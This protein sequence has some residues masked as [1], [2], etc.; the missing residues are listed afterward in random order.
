MDEILKPTPDALVA[1]EYY[2]MTIDLDGDTI[3][4]MIKDEYYDYKKKYYEFPKHL[5]LSKNY[6]REIYD[7][8]K[9]RYKKCLEPEIDYLFGMKVI[10]TDKQSVLKVY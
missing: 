2:G 9:K 5:V 6:Y 1:M 4:Q 8:I 10:T 7:W 3:T